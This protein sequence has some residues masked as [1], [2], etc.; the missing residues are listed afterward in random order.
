[1]KTAM[2]ILTTVPL[3]AAQFATVEIHEPGEWR[4]FSKGE[5]V[6]SPLV[7][8]GGPVRVWG[9][10]PERLTALEHYYLLPDT[11][12][13]DAVA[14]GQLDFEVTEGGIVRMLTTTSFGDYGSGSDWRTELTSR[15]QLELDGWVET[16]A[17]GSWLL[18]ERQC[19]AGEKFSIRTEKYHSPVLLRPLPAPVN[20]HFDNRLPLAGLN[21]SVTT[22]NEGATVEPIDPITNGRSL[23]WEWTAPANAKVTLTT[24]GSEV[25]TVL[26]VYA[27][28]FEELAVNDDD[29]EGGTSSALEFWA[30]TGETYFIVVDAFGAAEGAVNLSLS[31]E[32]WN[33]NAT[34][35]GRNLLMTWPTNAT[36]FRL[37]ASATLSGWEPAPEPIISGDEWAVK[38][39]MDEPSMFFRLI[40]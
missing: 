29:P 17:F 18:F 2:F 20:D 15:E 26:G 3:A 6:A 9:D 31:A 37:E 35:S 34:R 13:L 25:D 12:K 4:P 33:L 27:A 30:V 5:A 8:P 32:R 19:E 28:L 1:M 21:A 40:R 11:A 24:A 38:V 7:G 39:S 14:Y 22:S 23:W 10:I 36:G 16:E